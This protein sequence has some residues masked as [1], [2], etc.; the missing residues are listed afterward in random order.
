MNVYRVF[1]DAEH[2]AARLSARPGAATRRRCARPARPRW[3]RFPR[4]DS[5]GTGRP[6]ARTSTRS[7][8]WCSTATFHFRRG[9]SLWLPPGTW[10]PFNSQTT[11]WWPEAYPLL[12]L[13]SHCSFRMTDIWRSFVAQRCLWELGHGL[14]FHAPEVDPGS[15]RP[16]PDARLQ[17]RDARLHAERRDH[18]AIDGPLVGS[19][20]EAVADNLVKCYE[21]L[22]AAGFFPAE[23]YHWF[24]GGSRTCVRWGTL[25][26]GPRPRDADGP[27]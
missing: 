20:R 9:P 11:W 18:R 26:A 8:G 12:Y 2:L 19:G 6:R 25:T 3:S 5:A 1:T 17:G 15:Q 7:G 4:P 23:S 24:A 16:Q 27:G 21:A 13:P 22:T 14:V 10:C